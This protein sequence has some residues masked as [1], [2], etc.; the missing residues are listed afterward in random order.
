MPRQPSSKRPPEH[1]VVVSDTTRVPVPGVRIDA[2]LP[3]YH[4]TPLGRVYRDDGRLLLPYYNDN[5]IAV[6]FASGRWRLSLPKLVFL[7][8]GHPLLIERWRDDLRDHD[9]WLFPFGPNDELTGRTRCTVH[10]V[11]LVPRKEQIRFGMNSRLPRTQLPILS[12]PP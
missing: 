10:D 8:Y 1:C 4:I 6:S 7:A 5:Q 11:V 2:H 3:R 12:P 9:P